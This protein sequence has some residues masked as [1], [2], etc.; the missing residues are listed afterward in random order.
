MAHM[1]H[2]H[3]RTGSP[4]GA[5]QE[6]GDG[7]PDGQPTPAT[8]TL[9]WAPRNLPHPQCAYVLRFRSPGSTNNSNTDTSTKSHAGIWPQS[10][11]P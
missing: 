7:G 9:P 10:P 2:L 4:P 11:P 1:G 8:A 5:D 6:G 3:A